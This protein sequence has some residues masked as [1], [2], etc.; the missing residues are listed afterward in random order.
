MAG[1]LAAVPHV[2]Y[3]EFVYERCNKTAETDSYSS[4]FTL[5]V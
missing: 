5:R 2:E 3:E 1:L 4:S